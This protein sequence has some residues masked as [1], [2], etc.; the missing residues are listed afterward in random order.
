[1]WTLS[2]AT[3]NFLAATDIE[4]SSSPSIGPL[5][6]IPR[7]NPDGL[8][9]QVRDVDVASLRRSWIRGA[10]LIDFVSLAVRQAE[11]ATAQGGE[12]VRAVMEARR[13]D[14]DDV[15]L[16]LAYSG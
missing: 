2:V 12:E 1:M 13:H 15:A 3:P 10:A 16:A 9:R 7:P 6:E 14:V 5:S 4:P 11:V 8:E